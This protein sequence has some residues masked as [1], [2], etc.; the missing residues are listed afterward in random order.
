MLYAVYYSLQT[1]IQDPNS[2]LFVKM[3]DPDPYR[4]E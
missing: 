2:K 4:T 1:R 3:H